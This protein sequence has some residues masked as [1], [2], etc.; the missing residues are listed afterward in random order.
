M[1]DYYERFITCSFKN[2][3]QEHSPL[4]DQG[5]NLNFYHCFQIVFL[6]LFSQCFL[7]GFFCKFDIQQ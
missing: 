4:D 3:S 1:C 2:F 7:K 5:F 6:L